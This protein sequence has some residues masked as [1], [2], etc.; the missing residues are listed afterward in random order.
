MFEIDS[1]RKGFLEVD[2]ILSLSSKRRGTFTKQVI[3][4]KEKKKC[5][6]SI[7]SERD[8]SRL[9]A[10][11]PPLS[12]RRRNSNKA[13]YWIK[14]KGVRDQ[15]DPKGIPRGWS[16]PLS[17]FQ[18]T[19]NIYKTSYWIKRK[20]KRSI[21]KWFLKVRVVSSLYLPKDVIQ[22][23]I[24]QVIELK[25]KMFDPIRKGGWSRR[26]SAQQQ[27]AEVALYARV[28]IPV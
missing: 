19:S 10:S 28:R 20:E 1:I 22:Q 3:E 7:R 27:Q 24:K 9:I 25:E 16:Y 18:K 13:S 14:R 4:L 5:S 2:R 12:S 6:R 23:W 11:Y 17:I 26:I 8:S 15:S 21:R